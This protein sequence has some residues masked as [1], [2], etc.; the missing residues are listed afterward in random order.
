MD[1]IFTEEKFFYEI[2]QRK[3]ATYS[4]KDFDKFEQFFNKIVEKS[5]QNFTEIT[6]ISHNKYLVY[7]RKPDIYSCDL[8]KMEC[9]KMCNVLRDNCG[10][11]NAEITEV[12][13]EY[14]ESETGFVH[15]EDNIYEI[16]NLEFCGVEETVNELLKR[17]YA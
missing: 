10:I 16:D 4:Q 8:W 13:I 2:C 15:K 17:I 6:I 5:Y 11:A 3:F 1:R 14:S 9:E 7:I 12:C